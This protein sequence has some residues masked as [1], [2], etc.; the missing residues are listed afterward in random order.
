MPEHEDTPLSDL[1]RI[2]RWIIQ[3]SKAER[4]HHKFV[5]SIPG[6]RWYGLLAL[7]LLLLYFLFIGKLLLAGNSPQSYW[8]AML[9]GI[10][11]TLACL[12]ALVKAIL[13]FV[14]KH[15]QQMETLYRE[16]V[17]QDTQHIHRLTQSMVERQEQQHS[18]YYQARNKRGS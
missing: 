7:I 17:E 8:V 6:I 15:R 14:P 4:T 10:G 3:V 9:L 16:T 11:I 2:E 13:T 1:S 5:L 12:F 18:L